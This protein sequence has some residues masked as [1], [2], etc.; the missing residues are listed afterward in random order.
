VSSCSRSAT[1][2]HSCAFT[3][4]DGPVPLQNYLSELR[5]RRITADETTFVEWVGQFD[6]AD[7]DEAVVCDTVMTVYHEGLRAL[8]DRFAG[9]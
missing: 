1:W 4:T 3:I 8:T 5:L 6:V 7:A 2:T 9:R